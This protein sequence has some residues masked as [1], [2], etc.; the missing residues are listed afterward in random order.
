MESLAG[1]GHAFAS[2]RLRLADKLEMIRLDPWGMT[3]IMLALTF[4]MLLFAML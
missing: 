3:Y 2:K 4:D 1:S